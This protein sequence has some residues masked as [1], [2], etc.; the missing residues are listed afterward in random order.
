ML[1]FTVQSIGHRPLHGLTILG[2]DNRMAAQH[3]PRDLVRSNQWS[4][5]CITLNAGILTA[6]HVDFT[7]FLSTLSKSLLHLLSMPFRLCSSA[8]CSPGEG[9]AEVV[10]GEHDAQL[11][12]VSM[13]C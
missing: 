8:K 13:L 6:K 9:A 11:I 2:D 4:E 7:Y 12:I 1:S 5:Y 3:L 10:R